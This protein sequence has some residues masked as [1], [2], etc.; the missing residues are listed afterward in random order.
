[1][2]MKTFHGVLLDVKQLGVLILGKSGIGKSECAIDLIIGGSKLIADD[3][4]E[5]RRE[6]RSRLIGTG[7]ENIKYLMEIRGIG[8]VNIKNLFGANSVMDKKEIDMVV[9]LDQWNT[10]TEY[11]RLGLETM[12]YEIL[13]VKI[14]YII[15]PVSPGRNVATIV[16][17]AVRNQILKNSGKYSGFKINNN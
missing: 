7:P 6:R 3:V 17:V 12:S 5:I 1:M 11:E 8:V 2:P 14:P 4:I 16:E 13:G 10:D 9:E 15:I